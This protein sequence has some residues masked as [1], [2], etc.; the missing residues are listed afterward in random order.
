MAGMLVADRPT[1][2]VLAIGQLAAVGLV[3]TVGYRHRRRTVEVVTTGRGLLLAAL[4][5]GEVIVMA[6]VVMVGFLLPVGA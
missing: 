2:L 4:V 5:L 1:P 6:A 3:A